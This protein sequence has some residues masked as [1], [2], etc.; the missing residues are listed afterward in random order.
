MHTLKPL[1]ALLLV[2]L[3][4][5]AAAQTQLP[6]ITVAAPR[7]DIRT[8]CPDVDDELEDALA[9]TVR[10]RAESAD[11]DVRFLLHDGRISEVAMSDAPLPYRRML[12]RAVHGLSCDSGDNKSYTVSLRV[13]IVDPASSAAAMARVE[14]ATVVAA[15]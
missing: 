15:R 1:A 13:R 10:D 11:I 6:K 14:S 5:A 2:G 12:R 7:S 3:T 4:A 9:A 8:L